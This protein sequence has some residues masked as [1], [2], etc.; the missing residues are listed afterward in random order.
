MTELIQP[1]SDVGPVRHVP[2]QS[3]ASAHPS[4]FSELV[5]SHY[6][7]WRSREAGKADPAA[8][9][10]YDSARAAFQARHGEIIRAYWCSHVESA[11]ALTERKRL[12]GLRPPSFG[13]HRE[14]DWATKNAPEV[15][16]ELHRCDELAVRAEAVLTGVRQ[17]IC[18]ELVVSCASHL[19]SLVDRRAGTE[20]EARAAAALDRERAA[21]DKVQSYYCDAANGQAQLVYFGGIATVFLVIAGIAAAWLT[22]SWAGPVAA[23]VAGAAGAVVSVMQRINS[24]KF[25]LE[26]DVGGPYAFFLG[27]LRPLIGGAFAMAITFAF[28]GGLL[29]IPVAAGAGTHDRRLALLVLAFLAGFSERWAQDTLTSIVP[30][31]AKPPPPEADLQKGAV[32]E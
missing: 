7:W 28:D 25:E 2:A 15:A 24:G 13:F 27:G 14:T 17:R 26:Y 1:L 23:L 20:D 29:H 30:S 12:G 10:A 3:R 19:L 8:A 6:D 16:T 31:A 21:I 22:I 11:V 32:H 9:A 5:Y 18:L 4:G